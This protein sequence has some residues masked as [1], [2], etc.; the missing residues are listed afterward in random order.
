MANKLNTPILHEDLPRMSNALSCFIGNTV[1]KMMGWKFSGQFPAHKKMIIAVAPHTSN[2]DFVIG[3]A[4]AFT[5]KLKITFFAKNSLFIP[6]FSMLLKRWGGIPIKRQKA[7]GIV[8]QM[9]EKAR[10]A[11][12]MILCLAPEGTRSRRENWKTG[13]LHI[14]HKAN[15]PVFL[16]AFDYKKKRIELG[17]VLTISENIPLELQRIYQHYHTV[18]AK[19]PD[20][21]A[22]NLTPPSGDKD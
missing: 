21:V 15:M 2:W 1:L 9:A 4:V 22:T 6:P 11:E 18:H 17:P 19:F 5:L 20:N 10:N 3:I 16:V 13:F 12:K 14:A 8:D 7:H